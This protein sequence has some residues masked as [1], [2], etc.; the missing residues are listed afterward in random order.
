MFIVFILLLLLSLFVVVV[1]V[2]RILCTF[3][4]INKKKAGRTQ[5]PKA[6]QIRSKRVVREC[7]KES[8]KERGRGRARACMRDS[9]GVYAVALVASFVDIL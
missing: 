2:I 5:S 4:E 7:P 3:Q 8:D 9:T 1:V 6:K